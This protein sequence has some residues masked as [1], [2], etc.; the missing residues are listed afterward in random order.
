MLNDFQTGTRDTIM[1]LL[2]RNGIAGLYEIAGGPS[3][4]GVKIIF[5][6]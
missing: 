4:F 3:E 2:L 5:G 6:A 1:Q